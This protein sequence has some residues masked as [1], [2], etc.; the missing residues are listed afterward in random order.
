MSNTGNSDAGKKFRGW[1]TVFLALEEPDVSSLKMLFSYAVS[2]VSSS[3]DAFSSEKDRTGI[4]M[5]AG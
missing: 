3:E 2:S 4:K 5:G 1:T